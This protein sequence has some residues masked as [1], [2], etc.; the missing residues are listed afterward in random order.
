[1]CEEGEK[2]KG[3]SD[4]LK[5]EDRAKTP[6][7]RGPGEGNASSEPRV[8]S[9]GDAAAEAAAPEVAPVEE[10]PRILPVVT[11][12]AAIHTR[13]RCEK[14]VLR[15]VVER[16]KAIAWLPLVRKRHVYA[17]RVREAGLPL[18]TGYLFYDLDGMDRYDLLHYE[19][20]VRVVP[21]KDPVRLACELECLA[22][23][24]AVEGIQPQRVEIGPPGTPVEVVSGP[25]IGC[26]GELVRR[27]K[28]TSLVLKI[29]FLGFGAEV[30][31]DEAFC[32][33]IAPGD[34]PPSS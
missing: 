15:L 11:R 16:K 7:E 27:G 12:W 4:R 17:G 24:L 13:P 31:I 26:K 14:K 23:A 1:M 29:G 30:E 32:R 25:L 6:G 34:A 22:R 5:P 28:Q 2:A 33:P 21:T 18:F 8:E 19:K 20:V 10:P 9:E 3:D